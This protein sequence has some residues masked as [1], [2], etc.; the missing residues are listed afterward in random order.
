MHMAYPIF[1][2]ITAKQNRVCQCM[3]LHRLRHARAGCG[4]AV[5]AIVPKQLALALFEIPAAKNSLLPQD[6]PSSRTAF[7]LREGLIKPLL[8]RCAQERSL[9]VCPRSTVFRIDPTRA[10]SAASVADLSITVLPIVE[11][12][13]VGQPAKRHLAVDTHFRACGHAR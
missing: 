9:R 13:N 4:I 3:I 11:H 7:G 1:M 8:L 5:P 2:H 12:V 10:L 6:I